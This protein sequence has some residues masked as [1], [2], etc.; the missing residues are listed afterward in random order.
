MFY[1]LLFHNSPLH[2]FEIDFNRFLWLLLK[3]FD[4]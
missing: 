3:N 2:P 1:P 4:F